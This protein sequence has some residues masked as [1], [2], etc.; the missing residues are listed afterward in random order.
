M[1]CIGSIARLEVTPADQRYAHRSEII[2]AGDPVAGH[3]AAL[4]ELRQIDLSK[5]FIALELG[6]RIHLDE[7]SVR[8]PAATQRE[9]VDERD[10]GHARDGAQPLEQ[11]ILEAHT[12]MR[13]LVAT[14]VR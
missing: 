3:T 7:R 2:G 5:I 6:G 10:L 12:T 14:P 4:L 1:G 11:L 8:V 13:R 9:I